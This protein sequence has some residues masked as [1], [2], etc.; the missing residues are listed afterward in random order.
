MKLGLRIPEDISIT[1]FDDL[2][3]SDYTQPQL[4]TVRQD[5][6]EIG[7]MSALLLQNLMENKLESKHVFVE[8]QLVERE[9][10]KADSLSMNVIR[11]LILERKD[12][13]MIQYP[14]AF[15]FDLDGVITD[16]A[17]FHYLAWKKL[18][19]ELGIAIDR[20]FNEQ[21]KGISRMESLERI[22]AL[23]PSLIDVTHEEKEKLANQKNEHYLEL[24]E[25]Y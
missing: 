14:K 24:I 13:N 10:V 20:E 21:L 6:I 23:N 7:K 19:E 5:F 16:T 25:V 1:G 8:H 17:E 2:V 11:L 12:N 4:T 18:A 22:L 9:S 3:F 15:I